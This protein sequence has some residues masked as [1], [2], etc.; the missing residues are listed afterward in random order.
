MFTK[1]ILTVGN[2]HLGHRAF[3]PS[4]PAQVF[5]S[6]GDGDCGQELGWHA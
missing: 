5:S 6:R 1:C 4:L 2:D 3:F